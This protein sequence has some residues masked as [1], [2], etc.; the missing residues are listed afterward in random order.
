MKITYI[1]VPL[2]VLGVLPILWNTIRSLIIRR[3]L[4]R[5]IPSEARKYV[6]WTIDPVT[7]VVIAG[8]QNLQLRWSN[9][10]R[11]SLVA[12]PLG[13]VDPILEGCSWMSLAKAG[14][15][16]SSARTCS[17]RL[18]VD[19]S[20]KFDARGCRC[21]GATFTFLALGLSVDLYHNKL[22]DA[23]E[24]NDN[25]W[26]LNNVSGL[27]VMT[28]DR[29]PSRTLHVKLCG[30]LY[31]S[32]QGMAWFGIMVIRDSS[33]N[34][35]T[36]QSLLPS[37]HSQ[38]GTPDSP[39]DVEK[40]TLSFNETL[41]NMSLA[42]A[43]RWACYCEPIFYGETDRENILP[44]PQEVL[45]VR[46]D[47]IA[48]LKTYQKIILENEVGVIF[49]DA[50]LKLKILA[51]LGKIGIGTV[52]SNLGALHTLA[53][54]YEAPDTPQ[55][56]CLDMRAFFNKSTILT[57]LYAKVSPHFNRNWELW[58]EDT[59]QINLGT[60]ATAAKIWLALSVIQLAPRGGWK[61][62]TSLDGSVRSRPENTV[63]KRLLKDFDANTDVKVYID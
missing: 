29:G 22:S 23:L 11:V 20:L 8:L 50:D 14:I 32:R 48:D 59:R 45:R 6:S 7:G 56:C 51:A 54:A 18:I 43:L 55:H 57:E 36:F 42:L 21:D 33:G 12:N 5:A 47:A 27:E 38:I 63:L 17:Q 35:V 19:S 25:V 53:A 1:G 2:T 24:L 37:V 61:D 58:E 52:V 3:R 31:S 46:E 10:F 30:G 26:S 40:I 15:E 44:V 62:E 49:D 4:K 41:S 16:L 13:H 28:V 9:L 34:Y 39:P 60:T